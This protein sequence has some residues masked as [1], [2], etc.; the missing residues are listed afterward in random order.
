M[1]NCVKCG[2]LLGE[3]VTVCP[4]C[5]ANNA[6]VPPSNTAPVEA[7]P[8]QSV[9][10]E[11][12][13]TQPVLQ[14]NV[15]EQVQEVAQPV[16]Q[17]AQPV[18]NNSQEQTTVTPQVAPVKQENAAVTNAT[19]SN[20]KDKKVLIM[21]IIIGL[22]IIVVIVLVVLLFSKSNK[23]TNDSNKPII[24]NKEDNNNIKTSSKNID[25]QLGDFIFN[26]PSDWNFISNSSDSVIVFNKTNDLE[27]VVIFINKENK[28]LDNFI[29]IEN[30]FNEVGFVNV[31][32]E[33]LKLNNFEKKAIH[34][35]V[36]S[37]FRLYD[38]YYVEPYSGYTII[39]SVSWLNQSIKDKYSNQIKTLL[40]S[41]KYRTDLDV[42]SD[43]EEY[44]TNYNTF[45]YVIDLK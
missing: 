32:K 34:V 44:N 6:L 31:K 22:L 13:L 4:I 30:R 25:L 1:A 36:S 35:T 2:N 41:L 40:D 19:V 14:G 10:P 42:I 15:A 20:A 8:V 12:V 28:Y 9:I 17:G 24:D 43:M 23:T 21:G 11:E 16:P 7:A 29:D 26:V 33:E 45:K 5:G 18:I 37:S 3:N 39:I 38:V 27:D